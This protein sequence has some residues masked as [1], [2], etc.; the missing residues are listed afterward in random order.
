MD[1]KILIADDEERIVNLVS[2]FL[3]AAGYSTISAHDGKEALEI[4]KSL[5]LLEKIRTV[6]VKR[7]SNF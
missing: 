3:T 2:D 4:F 5:L 6:S 7:R 1:K